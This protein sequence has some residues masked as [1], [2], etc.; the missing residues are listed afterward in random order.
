MAEEAKNEAVEA[1]ETAAAPAQ[2]EVVEQVQ[3]PEQ[4]L[5][6]FN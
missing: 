5:K 4:F 3:N 2:Q 1:Q 6:D